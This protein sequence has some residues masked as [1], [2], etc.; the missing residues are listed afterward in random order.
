VAN[1]SKFNAM[2]FILNNL[3]PNWQQGTLYENPNEI[4]IPGLKGNVKAFRD[5]NHALHIDA[6]L[7]E[8]LWRTLGFFHAQDRLFQMTQT[9]LLG[10]GRLSELIG[11][12]GI[13]IDK[14]IRVFGLPHL[15]KGDW[16]A[17]QTS[18]D[19]KVAQMATFLKAYVSGINSWL[20]HPDFLAPTEFWLLGFR[21]EPFDPEDM[22][23]LLRLMYMQMSKS[24]G[25][26]LSLAILCQEIPLE[27]LR[28]FLSTDILIPNDTPHVFPFDDYFNH[29]IDFERMKQQFASHYDPGV[30]FDGSNAFAVSGKHT[31]SGNA[32]V[33][34]DPH[35]PLSM[36]SLFYVHHVRAKDTGYDF[37][38]VCIPGLPIGLLGH[39]KHLAWSITLTFNHCGDFWLEHQ[40][41]DG[42][43]E[44]EGEFY[45]PERRTETIRVKKGSDVTF[46][47]LTTKNGVVMDV[48]GLCDDL[49]QESG[50]KTFL[51]F[52]STTTMKNIGFTLVH[53]LETALCDNA[54]SA[55]KILSQVDAV[56][57]NFVFAD[58]S[59]NIGHMQIGDVPYKS[60][61]LYSDFPLPGW[62]R[63]SLW[64]G[65][66]GEADRV[67]KVNPESGFVVSSNQASV[68]ADHPHAYIYG[69]SCHASYRATAIRTRLEALIQK[70]VPLT[71]VELKTIQLDTT[72]NAAVRLVPLLCEQMK[73][74]G[75]TPPEAMTSFTD[76][77]TRGSIGMSYFIFIMTHAVRFTIENALANNPDLQISDSR[78][79]EL[80]S[81]AL[82][83]LNVMAPVCPQSPIGHKIVVFFE[84]MLKGELKWWVQNAGGMET[85]LSTALDLAAST[86]KKIT[87]SENESNW[88]WTS[89]AK[90]TH[91]HPLG[92]KFPKVYDK[93]G[94]GR[95][96]CQSSINKWQN[97]YYRYPVEENYK[98]IHTAAPVLRMVAEV[99]PDWR[100]FHFVTY[101]GADENSQ[102]PYS[103]NWTSRYYAHEYSTIEWDWDIVEK[104]AKAS[105]IVHD[106]TPVKTRKRKWCTWKMLI[107]G[108]PIVIGVAAYF[109]AAKA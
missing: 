1:F 75:I 6:D 70:N 43:F 16:I 63:Q 14:L 35:L 31:K 20:S 57:L 58:T 97:S 53:I 36:P 24:W 62:K 37:A 74:S 85:I 99:E 55:T 17:H 38:G 68:S 11:E 33:C 25:F 3:I 82:G 7:H 34:G 109:I 60:K 106:G 83:D 88:E 21:P 12:P 10:A 71:A 108:V 27:H 15:A 23:S 107:V 59:G 69:K 4:I 42:M 52:R 56:H 18:S 29:K 22:F 40:R 50:M 95:P 72:S 102:S 101:A 54:D 87:A 26:N 30:S 104:D 86:L 13:P 80:A 96:G 61:E 48:N 90:C 103:D 47:V 100:N 81:I 73:H 79:R 9:K 51:S 77:D 105:Y 41:Q 78:A 64:E 76:G 93:G 5:E 98:R 46:D 2:Q 19:P 94:Y 49:P 89:V 8:D 92:L 32:F 91:P 45:E 65:F 39:S 67:M 84:S 44:F 28:V 66:L